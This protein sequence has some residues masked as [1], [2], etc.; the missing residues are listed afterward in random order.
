MPKQIYK[1]DKF[2][3]GLNSASDPRDIAENEL[4]E[5]IDVMVDK[6]GKI[7]TLGSFG[8][9]DTV[10]SNATTN[11]Q[12]RGL[13]QFSHDRLGAES[14]GEHLDSRGDFSSNW[15]RTGDFAVDST[16]A[17]YTHSSAAGT[18][19]QTAANRLKQGE[20]DATYA[21]TYTISGFAET[22]TIFRIK[23]SGSQFA[24]ANTDLEQSDGTHTT[25]FTSHASDTDQPFTIEATSGSSGA[26]NIDN[27]SLRKSNEAETGDDYL[28]L[29][30]AATTTVDI[31]SRVVDE[32]SGTEWG[33]EKFDLGAETSGFEP[34]MYAV[35][36]ALRVCDGKFANSSTSK[37]F[38]YIDRTNFSGLNAEL[39]IDSW[40]VEDQEIKAGIVGDAQRTEGI[41]SYAGSFVEPIVTDGAISVSVNA[42]ILNTGG[43]RGF[44]NYYYSLIYD[45]GQESKLFRL[46][47]TSFE[48]GTPGYP[49]DDIHEASIKKYQVYVNAQEFTGTANPGF[50]KRCTGAKIYWKKV[51][52]AFAAYDDAYLFLTCDWV[53][54][55]KSPLADSYAAWLNYSTSPVVVSPP[56]EFK[57]EVRFETY[58]TQTGFS[59]DCVSLAARY[60]TSVVANRMT[61][62]GNIKAKNDQST[63]AEVVMGDAIIKS[64]VNQFDSFP[65]DRMLEVSIRDGD[66]IIHLEEY[67]DRILQFKKNKLSILNI[68]QEIEFVEDE[69]TH[70]G[71]NSP[72]SVVKTD[73]GIVWANK[74]GV[75][76]YDGSKVN[77]LLEKGGLKTISDSDW[78]DFLPADKDPMVGYIPNKRQI[79]VADAVDAGGGGSIF[80]FDFVTKS[81]IKGSAATITDA[82]KSNFAVDWDGELI[83]H[84]GST[85]YQWNDAPATSTSVDIKTKDIDFGQPGQVKRI[86]K[87]YVT[88]RGSASNIQL[89]YATNGEQDNSDYTE[90]G[91]ELP[92]TSAVTD[93][94][95]TAITPTKFSCYSV[96]LRLFTTSGDTTPANFEI[97][98]ITIVYRLKGQR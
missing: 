25:T 14:A 3:G 21:F 20:V 17:T 90:A 15:D 42:N 50:K 74:H 30:D 9:H 75:F 7:T 79:I 39:A 55:V 83:Y 92:V 47:D 81:W 4:S 67:A 82:V 60:K 11:S 85:T 68:S 61:F 19:I 23:G 35:D 41:G 18:L 80:L 8:T 43:M 57:D 58:R 88:H 44:K 32:A 52:S 22:I 38:G 2:H 24:S 56:I 96:R 40:I 77:N 71:V 70:K 72:G 62:I 65:T 34:S 51:D 28:A 91:S 31:Y 59:E 10:G 95:T 29:T 13:F 66:E 12:G 76:W 16:D 69:L 64:P 45:G 46:V 93:W 33:T 54:G 27:V 89:S 98:D 86:Y 78:D 49:S 1:I 84:S 87:F 97:N 53:R 5:A 6:V 63:A 36:G 37:W 26:L 48:S 73:I 94:V